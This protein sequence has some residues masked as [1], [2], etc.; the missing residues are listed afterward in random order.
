MFGKLISIIKNNYWKTTTIIVAIGFIVFWK[1]N[2]KVGSEQS[3]KHTR[4]IVTAKIENVSTPVFFDGRIEPLQVYSVSSPVEGV[5]NGMYFK[6]G[7]A[8]NH[9][10]KL[11]SISSEKLEKEYIDSI[12]SYMK[13]LDDY[14]EKSR[15]FRGAKELW[16]LKFISENDYHADKIAQQEAFF[17]LK[18]SV[19]SLQETLQ[20]LGIKTE[21]DEINVQ[22]KKTIEKIVSRKFD[23]YVVTSPYVGVALD[24]KSLAATLR[25]KEDKN[26]VVGADVRQGEVLLHIGDLNGI[27]VEIKVNEID[28]NQIQSGQKA[29][30][31]GPGFSDH[32]LEGKVEFVKSQAHRD[33]G[34]LPTFPVRIIIEKL[35]PEQREK[36]KVG[37][38]S[39]VE[40]DVSEKNAI[41]VPIEAV[42][43]IKGADYV[44]VKEVK[45][46][47]INAVPVVLGRTTFDAIE[48]IKGLNPGDQVVVDY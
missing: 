33:S 17:V 28:V 2:Y 10:Q 37:M 41:M 23:S 18:Q 1:I 47:K 15:K 11:F 42:F 13:A 6:Y 20:K 32:I 48:I 27:A 12:S 44:N 9:G 16:K 22:N 45:T 14:N 21:L 25:T 34:A 38:S 46:D 24:P 43:Q 8:I 7:Q 30:V 39:K 36:I 35:T 40:I 19:K 3:K 26:I 29:K 5:V 4:E 31:T